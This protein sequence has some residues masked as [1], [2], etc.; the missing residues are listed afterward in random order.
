MKTINSLSGGK[1]SSYMA[2]HYP[3]DYNI[4]SL[5]KIDAEYCKPKDKSLVQYVSDKIGEDFIA[6]AESDK[7]LYVMR[8]LEQLIGQNII[9]VSGLSFDQLCK[10]RKALPNMMQRFCTSEMKMIPIADWWFKNIN[11]KVKMQVGFRYD[12]MERAE[13]FTTEIKI[14]VGKHP[15][16]KNKWQTFNW[17]EGSFPLIDNKINHF[18]VNEWSKTTNLIFPPDS[19]CVGCFW[20]PIQQLRKNWED[21]PLKMRWFSEMEKLNARNR[22]FKNETTYENIKKIGLQMD[23]NFGTGSGCQA[24]YCTD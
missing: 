15:S 10:Q 19:N 17:R 1:T 9:W 8:D 14:K 7:T 21:E 13:R 6:T 11:E 22:R 18:Q 12:E 23:F 5:V 20:K 2:K 24:G 4:F 16:G 3:A